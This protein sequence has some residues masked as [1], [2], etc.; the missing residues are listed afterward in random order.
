MSE[1]F[2][3]PDHPLDSFGLRFPEPVMMV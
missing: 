2:S 3:T 1:L